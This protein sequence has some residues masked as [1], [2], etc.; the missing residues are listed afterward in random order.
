MVDAYK[1]ADSYTAQAESHF[2]VKASVQ[3]R[4][5]LAKIA[6]DLNHLKGLSDHR[7]LNEGNVIRSSWKKPEF[8]RGHA[9]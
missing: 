4:L 9:D 6:E 7:A 5:E 2:C 1:Q 8:A 3:S